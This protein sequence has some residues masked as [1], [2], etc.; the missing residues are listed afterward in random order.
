MHGT[1]S[2]FSQKAPKLWSVFFYW[3][4]QDRLAAENK[5]KVVKVQPNTNYRDKYKHLIGDTA[6]KEAAQ[7]T[8]TN[9]SYGFGKTVCITIIR[10][11]LVKWKKKSK[12]T[13]V[14]VHVYFSSKCY[15]VY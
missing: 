15:I 8:V 4:E 3:K 7:S 2:W 12:S 11:D 5:P 14:C 6:A 10:N 1:F 9:R 13:H